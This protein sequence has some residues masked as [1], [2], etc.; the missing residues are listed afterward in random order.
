MKVAK[1]DVKFNADTMLVV[2]RKTVGKALAVHLKESVGLGK[3]QRKKLLAWN[4]NTEMS[5]RVF[6]W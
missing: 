2:T 3:G 5:R 6:G 1:R 4:S